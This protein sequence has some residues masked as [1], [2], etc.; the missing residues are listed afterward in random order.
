MRSLF[1]M[2]FQSNPFLGQDTRSKEE[3]QKLFQDLDQAQ[4]KDVV[5][6]GWKKNH[7]N[8]QQDLGQDYDGWMRVSEDDTKY[9]SA[10][11]AV[12][13]ALDKDPY[14]DVDPDD[15][16]AANYWVNAIN[17]LYVIAVNHTGAQ[18]K[19]PGK[20]GN[21]PGAPGAAP[22]GEKG[23]NTPLIVGVGAAAVFGLVLLA[24]VKG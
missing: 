24:T 4:D 16:M 5:V 3:R 21:A 20:A 1:L 8:L 22:G 9:G 15:Q 14:G 18:A 10:A 7:P 12:K 11:L 17:R 19:A 23:L 13:K 2:G 6:E